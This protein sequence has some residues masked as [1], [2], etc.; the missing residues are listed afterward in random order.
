[1]QN[2]CP[3]AHTLFLVNY[4]VDKFSL[5]RSWKRQ[6]KLGTKV[7]QLSRIYFF[8]LSIA[9]MAVLSSYYWSGF[10]F[11]NLCLLSS[12][13]GEYQGNWTLSPIDSDNTFT[14][15]VDTNDPS[16]QFCVQDFLRFKKGQR[17]FP[18]VAAFQPAGKEWMTSEQ[19]TLTTIHGWSVLGILALIL[20]SFLRMFL[21]N[22]LAFFQSTYEPSGKDQGI[23]FSDVVSRSVYIP[24]VESGVYSY[25]LLACNVDGI[26][27]ELL[28]W[29]D[30]DRPYSFYDLTKDADVLTR[31]MDESVRKNVFSQVTHYPPD[32]E[33]DPTIVYKEKDVNISNL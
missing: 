19:A 28:E 32:Q 31:G 26:D 7:S 1:M 27:E 4:Y 5:M 9:A 3:I 30:P 18:F 13:E 22:I 12:T 25:P 29:S 15:E 6:A 16:F 14:R 33:E 2:E 8:P 11:D 10:P 21:Q 20:F 17:S 23:N 24:Q